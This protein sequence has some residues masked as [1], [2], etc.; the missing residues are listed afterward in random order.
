MSAC[1]VANILRRIYSD[2]L[3]FVLSPAFKQ[4]QRSWSACM[5]NNL[6]KSDIHL[7]M[8]YYHQ[9]IPDIPLSPA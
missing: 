4:Y 3:L 8:A 2:V 9:N 5:T 6:I 7:F 1:V